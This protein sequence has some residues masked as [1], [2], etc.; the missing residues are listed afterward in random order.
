MKVICISKQGDLD[1][2]HYKLTSGKIYDVISAQK[3]RSNPDKGFSHYRVLDDNGHKSSY[4]H[5]YFMT[6]EKWRDIQL[7]QVLEDL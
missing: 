1:F 5:S 7:S 4:W 3:F 6:L 2:A